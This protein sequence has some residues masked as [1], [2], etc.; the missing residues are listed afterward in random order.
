MSEDLYTPEKIQ[1]DFE[2]PD[3]L[4]PL[5][6]AHPRLLPGETKDEYFLLFNIMVCSILP[7]TDLEWLAT[8]D[9]EQFP[10][11]L[12]HIRSCGS[13]WRIHR[14]ERHREGV[15]C[16][17]RGSPRSARRPFVARL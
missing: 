7:E 8:I 11:N 5:V 15:R 17:S 2:V 16:G 9:L 4:M 6:V 1:F 12:K 3:D 10:L 14:A 13:S